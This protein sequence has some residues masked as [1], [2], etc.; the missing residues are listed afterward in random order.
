MCGISGRVNFDLKKPVNRASIEAMTSA[1][2]YRGPDAEGIFVKNNVGLGHRRLA[3]IDL[4]EAGKQPMS[5]PDEKLW[6]TFNGEI[7]NFEELRKDLQKKGHHFRS[8][9]DTEIILYLYQEYGENCLQYL[10]G[11]FA[12]AIWDESKKKL[13]LARDRAGK[14]PLKYYMGQDFIVFGSELKT[15]LSFPDVPREIDLQ[16]IYHYLTLQ[17]VPHPRTGFKD[18]KK[19]PPA[20]FLTVDLSG[21]KPHVVLKKYWQLDFSHPLSLSEIEWKERLLQV[22]DESVRLRM[23]SDVP[24]G[25]FLSGGLDSSAVVA[26]MSKHSTQPIKTFS[27][28]F[29]EEDYNELPYARR[30][31][32]TFK[33]DHQEFIVKPDAL[34]ILPNLITHY[35]EPYADSSAIPTWY[36]AQM[37]RQHVTVALN[38]DGGDENFAGYGMFPIHVFA[39][40]VYGRLPAFMRQHVVIPSA[41]LFHRIKK[42][43]FSERC[44]RFATSYETP[45]DLRYLYYISYFNPEQKKALFRPDFPIESLES[46]QDLF[47]NICDESRAKGILD[48]SLFFNFQSYLPDDLLVKVDIATMAFGLEGRSPLLD[49]HFLE[50]AAQIPSSLKVKGFTTKYIFKKALESVLPHDIIYRKKK[51]FGVPLEHWFRHEL[52]SYAQEI[53]L[54]K[55]T[56]LHQWLRRDAIQTLFNE[57]LETKINHSNRLWALLTLELWSR[58]FFK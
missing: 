55:G 10:R 3:I 41:R 38:G 20:H 1:I 23:I 58:T 48:R 5:T 34:S 28:G 2:R 21:S 37:T 44:L 25:A 54:A 14:K 18:I 56:H 12:F 32:N 7:Y 15:F 39:D 24:L 13:F 43:T 49:H 30:V 8:K 57:H 52:K 35:E 17:Y 50:L 47:L 26:F 16:A 11:M 27:I 29:E 4:S 45:R 9:T 31:A 51:G 36:L 53:L 22:F 40:H 6:I 42:D 19:L 46:T 33:T